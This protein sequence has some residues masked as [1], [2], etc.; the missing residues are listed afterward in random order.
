[1][2]KVETDEIAYFFAQDKN[3][4]FTTTNNQTYPADYTLDALE[5]LLDPAVFFRINRK[6]LVNMDSIAGMTAYSR[7]RIKLD[8]KPAPVSAE[9]TIVSIE[10]SGDFRKW[11]DR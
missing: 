5:T 11:V 1:M 10:R 9:D 4:L 3:V 6:F 8:L 2:K 7:G